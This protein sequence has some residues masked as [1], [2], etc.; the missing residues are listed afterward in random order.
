MD[1]LD[2]VGAELDGLSAVIGIL[3]LSIAYLQLEIHRQRGRRV[4]TIEAYVI[5]R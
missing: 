1:H 3:A 5:E 4:F 2:A